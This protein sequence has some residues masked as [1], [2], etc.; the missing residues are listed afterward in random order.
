MS[1]RIVVDEYG[2]PVDPMEP[3]ASTI[4]ELMDGPALTHKG[5]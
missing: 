3:Y 5:A 2:N 1:D 4:L